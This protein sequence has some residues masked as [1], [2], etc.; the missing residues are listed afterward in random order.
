MT[1]CCFSFYHVFS[2]LSSLSRPN[3]LYIGQR[4]TGP[5]MMHVSMRCL[6]A[7]VPALPAVH[8]LKTE[9]SQSSARL[10]RDRSGCNCLTGDARPNR[11]AVVLRLSLSRASGGLNFESYESYGMTLHDSSSEARGRYHFVRPGPHRCETWAGD[12]QPSASIHRTDGTIFCCSFQMLRVQ[13]K[14]KWSRWISW[15]AYG[16]CTGN[17]CQLS[18]NVSIVTCYPSHVH[19]IFIRQYNSPPQDMPSFLTDCASRSCTWL[20]QVVTSTSRCCATF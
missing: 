2:A 7:N 11:A 4:L 20:C 17:V 3:A 8:S 19:N 18:H 14:V 6:V 9:H 13:A 15:P 16:G 10:G 12:P 5:D 1:K